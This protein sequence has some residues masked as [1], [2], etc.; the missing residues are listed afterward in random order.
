MIV[1]RP[2]VTF[3]LETVT[4]A[5]ESG[6]EQ[7]IKEG[8]DVVR[9]ILDTCD[10][11]GRFEIE[12]DEEGLHL[13]GHVK[14]IHYFGPGDRFGEKDARATLSYDEYQQLGGPFSILEQRTYR[15][16]PTR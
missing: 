5:G 2:P 10:A 16:A 1:E 12:D 4:V 9:L 14:A 6:G 7:H 3:N 15:A 8:A 11:S 13:A